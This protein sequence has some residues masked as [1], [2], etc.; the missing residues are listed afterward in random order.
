LVWIPFLPASL[1]AGGH[2][3]P[4]PM[5]TPYRRTRRR[6][7]GEQRI[8][9]SGNSYIGGFRTVGGRIHGSQRA[10]PVM[11]HSRVQ[12]AAKGPAT[13]GSATI[14][15]AA[16]ER[17]VARKWDEEI[18]PQLVEYIRIPNKSP[19]FEADW[20]KLGHMDAAVTLMETWARGQP[21]GGMELEVVRLEGRTPL[22]FIDIPATN[23]GSNEDC[24][25][26]YGH[27]YK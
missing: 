20:A 21:I 2:S 6:E 9:V 16:V 3:V 4:I 15:A 1:S 12:P 10:R 19:M 25:I 18:V 5:P 23:G 11:D 27:L 8:V 17:F 22:I 24:V 7:A 14:E 26:L 13:A